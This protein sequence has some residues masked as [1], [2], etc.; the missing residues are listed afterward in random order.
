MTPQR[1]GATEQCW[2]LTLRLVLPFCLL[3]II[4]EQSTPKH[5]PTPYKTA[6]NMTRKHWPGARWCMS[7]MSFT[8][9]FLG[10]TISPCAFWHQCRPPQQSLLNGKSPSR[11]NPH[12]PPK[13]PSASS[14]THS[15]D[16]HTPPWW[17]WLNPA[18]LHLSTDVSC[19]GYTK[20]R[21]VVI[22]M[23][24]PIIKL[25]NPKIFKSPL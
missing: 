16:K 18:N 11:P 6:A 7:W 23:N 14:Y 15:S 2:S 17:D 20:N 22:G 4:G 24:S 19:S 3:N 12:F 13:N 5:W 25:V 9:S 21:E 8:I 1:F 10:G